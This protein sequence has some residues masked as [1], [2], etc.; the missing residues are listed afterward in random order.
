MLKLKNFLFDLDGVLVNACDWHY[1]TL[2][3]A[4]EHSGYQKISVEDHHDKFNGLPSKIKLDMLGVPKDLQ[5]NIIKQKAIFLQ[6]YID[7][8][9]Q[10]DLIKIELL[11][12][13]KRKGGK[14]ACV[15]N[16]VRHTAHDI[17]KKMKILYFFDA[18][19][20]NEDVKKNKP[21]PE[22]YNYAVDILDINPH[23]TLIVEDSIKGFMAA[24]ASSVDLLWKVPDANYVTVSNFKNI[25][26][27]KDE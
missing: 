6:E 22:P 8:N 21:D 15:T 12:H 10:E 26:E 7:D 14:I 9:C 27:A 5:E 23:E 4:L 1:Q 16:S 11:N 19:I 2:N 25:F 24:I 20:S 18:V 13:L 3:A 17:L